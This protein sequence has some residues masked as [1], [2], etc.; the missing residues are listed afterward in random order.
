VAV[1]RRYA[2][3]GVVTEHFYRELARR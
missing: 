3:P 2:R 1:D